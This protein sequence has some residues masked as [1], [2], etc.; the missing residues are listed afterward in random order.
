VLENAVK[1]SE[2]DGNIKI[3]VEP[4][5]IYTKI[6]IT[7][8]GIGIDKNDWHLIFKRFYRGQNVSGKEGAGLGLYIDSLILE[9]QGGYI[10]VDS[11]P[12]QF[13]SFSLFLQ[14]CKN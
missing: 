12:G 14:N 7:D 6:I 13:T 4:M 2:P 1:Y 5:P 8:N 3:T 10:M 11:I 9:K